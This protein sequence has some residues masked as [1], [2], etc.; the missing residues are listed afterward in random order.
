MRSTADLAVG[1]AE[2]TSLPFFETASGRSSL[3]KQQKY[4]YHKRNGR[5]IVCMW[6]TL[7]EDIKIPLL[8]LPFLGLALTS[9]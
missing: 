1:K 4:C 2:I 9:T 8:P 5:E 3:V 6:S 7:Q